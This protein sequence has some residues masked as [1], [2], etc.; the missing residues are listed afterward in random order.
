MGLNVPLA[1]R[2]TPYYAKRAGWTDK[3]D[4]V[5]GLL[6]FPASYPDARDFVK[7]VYRWQLSHQL[8]PDGMLGP[9]TWKKMKPAVDSYSGKA[10]VVGPH[11][12]WI[13]A[14]DRAANIPAA[15]HPAQVFNPKQSDVEDR[16]IKEMIRVGEEEKLHP[17]LP[18]A[19]SNEYLGR[20]GYPSGLKTIPTTAAMS[21]TLEIGQVWQGISGKRTIVGLQAGGL[22]PD[23]KGLDAFVLFMTESGQGYEERASAWDSD[24]W[25]SVD[26]QVSKSLAPLAK[27][28][29]LEVA[30]LMGAISGTSMVGAVAMVGL[31]AL[32]WYLQNKKKIPFWE[33]V[34]TEAWHADKTLEQI[35]P[36]L[37]KKL[38]W[39]ILKDTGVSFAKSLAE[40]ANL[41]RFVGQT[42]AT[43]GKAL[44]TETFP[45]LT[46]SFKTVLMG[47]LK[48]LGADIGPELEGLSPADFLRQIKLKLGVNPLKPPVGLVG[49]GVHSLPGGLVRGVEHTPGRELEN[50]KVRN[51]TDIIPVLKKLGADISASDAEQIEREIAAHSTEIVNA[52]LKVADAVAKIP[53]DDQ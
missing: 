9:N 5:C 12:K 32:Q 34:I 26:H 28:L 51:F 43:R 21:Q 30:F 18:V 15:R 3:V 6:G 10:P 33:D 14:I 48:D 39:A 23:R 52:F 7:A 53:P 20:N 44:F 27:M 37:E 31:S 45:M 17:E 36:T 35:A 11:P 24:M 29:D 41:A 40:P 42:V 25:A 8:D 22:T 2:M 4:N 38:F 46:L 49:G 13:Y 47:G 1:I 19:V 50:F 16:V